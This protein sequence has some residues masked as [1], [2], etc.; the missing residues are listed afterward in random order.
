MWCVCIYAILTLDIDNNM[1]HPNLTVC[2]PI[3]QEEY[4][5][6]D[7]DPISNVKIETPSDFIFFF[8]KFAD[9]PEGALKILKN[10][11]IL[12]PSLPPPPT[13]HFLLMGYPSG[14]NKSN[15]LPQRRATDAKPLAVIETDI[16]MYS[17]F[18]SVC[19]FS[20]LPLPVANCLFTSN[21]FIL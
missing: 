20:L 2:E 18:N 13:S 8:C 19:V 17:I 12:L 5:V 10:A 14:C 3:N 4:G 16:L 11:N 1:P 7:I 9:A 21:M 15:F 6:I